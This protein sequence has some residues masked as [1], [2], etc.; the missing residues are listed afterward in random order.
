M[1]LICLILLLQAHQPFSS[2]AT[3]GAGSGA[4]APSGAA[5]TG[6]TTAGAGGGKSS[7]NRRASDDDSVVVPSTACA[8][9][10]VS[11]WVWVSMGARVVLS[12]GLWRPTYALTCTTCTCTSSACMSQATYTLR[13]GTPPPLLPGLSAGTRPPRLRA[14][15]PTLWL[16]SWLA[17]CRCCRYR[18]ASSGVRGVG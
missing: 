16:A 10:D 8:P 7:S 15:K 2:G 3:G 4:P 5:G 1:A 9:L 17:C 12:E 14:C 18:Q 13:I 6:G 11:W